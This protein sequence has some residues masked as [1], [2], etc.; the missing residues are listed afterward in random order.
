MKRV[1]IKGGLGNQMF[2]Y[3][4]GRGRML[5]GHAVVFDISAYHML[6][7]KDTP[8]HFML[9]DFTL[10]SDVQF[11]LSTHKV[12]TLFR[13]IARL[14]GFRKEEYFQSEDYFK[15]HADTLR[16]EFVLR[17]PL[18]KNANNMYTYITSSGLTASIHVRRG[19]YVTNEKT[20]AYHGVCDMAYYWRA[21]AY[22]E[23]KAAIDTYMVFSDDVEWAKQHFVGDQFVVVSDVGVSDV[24]EM[25]LMSQC[26]HNIIANSTFSWWGA[27]LNTHSDKIVI[28]P[29]TW[30][31]NTILNK[32]QRIV[33]DTWIRL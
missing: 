33:P 26:H 29:Q 25:Y 5:D 15:R 24:E 23:E 21:M 12:H 2:Q 16:Q 32:K 22:I 20:H 28:A 7:S 3:A 27:W 17:T 13:K 4:Y 11:I 30:F 14:V 19:D 10:S 1:Y 8:R 31:N 18:S 9:Q 6:D